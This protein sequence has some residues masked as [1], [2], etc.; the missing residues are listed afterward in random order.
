MHAG[1]DAERLQPFRCPSGKAVQLT[2][3]EGAIVE[4]EGYAVRPFARR[5]LQQTLERDRRRQR[6][7]PGYALR[8]RFFPDVRHARLLPVWSRPTAMRPHA[9]ACRLSIPS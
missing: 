4:V 7:I 8:I 1:T 6:R 9:P 2:K 3:G 5:G